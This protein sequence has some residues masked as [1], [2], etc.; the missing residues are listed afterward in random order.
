MRDLIG[1]I[2]Q[3]HMVRLAIHSLEKRA[4]EPCPPPSSPD[5]LA[6]S[7]GMTAIVWRIILPHL[8]PVFLTLR[9]GEWGNDT[10]I[11]TVNARRF[12]AI[13]LRRA[14]AWDR[15]SQAPPLPDKIPAD[16]K[17]RFAQQGFAAS[18]KSP[19]PLSKVHIFHTKW[20]DSFSFTDGIT[21]TLWLIA[22]EAP[23]FP[24]S[25]ESSKDAC[26]ISAMAGEGAPIRAVELCR[27]LQKQNQSISA[28]PSS[29][30]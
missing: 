8:K 6:S 7:D 3:R 17:Y 18:A 1:R 21:R 4:T 15:Q 10:H 16:R 24:I 12:Y 20:G 14:L 13:W 9:D 5:W 28:P 29:L 11:V 25:T 19:V 27:I 26:L 2:V 23:V 22:N 30:P